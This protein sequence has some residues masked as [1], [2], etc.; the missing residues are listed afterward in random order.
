MDETEENIL[1]NR[2]TGTKHKNMYVSLQNKLQEDGLR[3]EGF[4]AV[5]M[6]NAVC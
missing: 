1:G 6:K 2:K 4:T 5:I 3:L